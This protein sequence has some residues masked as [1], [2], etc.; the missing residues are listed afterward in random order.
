M[1][2]KN[3]AQDN[4]P[5]VAEIYKEGLDTGIA[6]FQNDIPIWES[7]DKDHLP[8]CRIAAFEDNEM[9]GWAA[10]TP[11]SSRCVYAGVGEVSIY[12]AANFRGKGVGEFLLNNLIKES[13]QSGLW[14]L[15]SG[16]FAENNGS[17]KLHEKCGFRQIG[18]REK[19]G[20]KNGIW[21]DTILM[22]RR[23]KIVGGP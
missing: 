18:Y 22:E 11:V 14:T 12:I 13:E 1:D 23:S 5:Q 7:W 6:T 2:I 16:I 20:Q 4:F 9:V 8:N 17:I 19:I 21:K 10:L 15:Q 3:I